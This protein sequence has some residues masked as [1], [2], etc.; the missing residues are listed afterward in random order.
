M[1]TCPDMTTGHH[2]E[3]VLQQQVEEVKENSEVR[4]TVTHIIFFGAFAHCTFPYLC[5]LLEIV[6]DWKTQLA[7]CFLVQRARE[8]LLSVVEQNNRTD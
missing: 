4:F 6:K 2:Q 8:E 5:F 3:S 7:M 1:C